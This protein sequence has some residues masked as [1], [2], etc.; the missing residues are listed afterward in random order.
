VGAGIDGIVP[1]RGG[2]TRCATRSRV[3]SG[4][5]ADRL[6]PVTTVEDELRTCTN[7]E[8]GQ[9]SLRAVRLPEGQE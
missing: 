4:Q 5:Y 2:N 8:S 3:R 6:S 9:L 7:R 1:E